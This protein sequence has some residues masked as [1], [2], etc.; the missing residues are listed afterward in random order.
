MRY[1]VLSGR[2]EEHPVRSVSP[3]I[4][5]DELG[6]PRFVAVTRGAWAGLVTGRG[7]LVEP[8]DE[9]FRAHG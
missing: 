5:L 3:D 9:A 1:H 8:A 2:Q 7:G 6:R 4:G